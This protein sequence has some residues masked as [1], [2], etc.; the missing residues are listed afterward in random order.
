MRGK[1]AKTAIPW[2]SAFLIL[3]L[4]A[5]CVPLAPIAQGKVVAQDETKKTITVQDE[6]NLGAEPIV[7]DAS[8]AEIGTW[9]ETGDR[10]RIVYVERDGKYC[11]LRVMNMTRQAETG[12]H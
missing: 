10:V 1:Q 6:E 5:A 4:L 9:P 12:G 11:A 8:D 3:S 2:I 7:L